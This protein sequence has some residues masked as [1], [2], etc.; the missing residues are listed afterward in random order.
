[1]CDKAILESVETLK[2]PDCHKNQEMCNKA[3]DNYTHALEFVPHCHMTQK[4]SDKAVDTH[5][6]TIEYVPD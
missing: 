5:P 2:Y 6:S 3:I 4:V 1:M